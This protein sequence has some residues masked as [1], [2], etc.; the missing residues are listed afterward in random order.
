MGVTNVEPEAETGPIFGLIEIVLAPVT[1]H[2]SVVLSPNV[3]VVGLAEK[4]LITGGV[5][6]VVVFSVL[7]T[8][9]VS[10]VTVADLVIEP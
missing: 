8:P 2:V 9:V 10:T 4:A 6:V 3:I 1:A 7:V 5:V